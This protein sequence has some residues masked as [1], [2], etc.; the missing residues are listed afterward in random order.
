[1]RRR[2]RWASEE[3]APQR[4][5]GRGG[6]DCRGAFWDMRQNTCLDPEQNGAGFQVVAR[7]WLTG[8]SVGCPL[9]PYT[10]PWASFRQERPVTK[11]AAQPPRSAPAVTHSG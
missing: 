7:I 1:L 2:K 11:L 8:Q 10:R 4:V 5:S 6:R 9:P 3:V